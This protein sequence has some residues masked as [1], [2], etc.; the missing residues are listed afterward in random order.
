VRSLLA[1][2]AVGAVLL[3]G[4][5]RGGSGASDQASAADRATLSSVEATVGAVESQ[6][7]SDGGG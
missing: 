1:L 4:C 2:A 6:V 7:A 5:D 3:A